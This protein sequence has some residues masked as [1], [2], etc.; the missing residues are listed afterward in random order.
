MTEFAENCAIHLLV[1]D[2][3]EW[4][5]HVASADLAG[6]A[7]VHVSEIKQQPWGMTEFVL[8]DPSGVC[9]HIAQNTPGF[10]P[11]GRFLHIEAAH[12]V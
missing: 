2:V 10:A 9:W 4:H 1:Q 7:G 5:A 11:V 3:H 6:F 8:I 12:H